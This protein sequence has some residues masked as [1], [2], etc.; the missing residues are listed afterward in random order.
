MDDAASVQPKAR[1]GIAYVFFGDDGLRAGWSLLLFVLLVAAAFVALYFVHHP[2]KHAA[3]NA[4]APKGTIIGEGITFAVIAIAALIMSL[5]ERRPFSRYGF[6]RTNIAPDALRGLVSGLAMLSLLVGLLD[7]FGWLTFDGV[8][9]HG[10]AVASYG[11]EWLVAFIL[12]GFFEEFLFRGYL[13]FTLARGVT[14]IVRALSKGNRHAATIGFWVSATVFSVILF[15]L[16]HTSNGGETVMG[17]ITVSLAG[18]VFVFALYWTGSLW[19]GVGF[20]AAWDW[21]QSYLYGVADSGMVSQGRL[22]VTHPIGPTALSGGTT[23]PEGSILVVPVLLLSAVVIWKTMPRRPAP[24]L[25]QETPPAARL[26]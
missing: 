11:G 21:A 17:I 1:S 10:E 5:I 19:W 9:L 6:R 26:T 14:G 18:L 23:G 2:S 25:E 24:G 20:H 7:L 8:A 22:F 4:A 16:A 3:A 15:A 13:Q 12:V